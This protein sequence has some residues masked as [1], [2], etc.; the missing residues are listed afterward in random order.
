[1]I[2]SPRPLL[3][4]ARQRVNFPYFTAI[5]ICPSWAACLIT[6]VALSGRRQGQEAIRGCSA[7]DFRAATGYDNSKVPIEWCDCANDESF[8]WKNV[9][10]NEYF[11]LWRSQIDLSSRSEL[12]LFKCGQFRPKPRPTSPLAAISL[13]LLPPVPSMLGL[14]KSV[15]P[16]GKNSLSL[17]TKCKWATHFGSAWRSS[18]N[19]S[20]FN[21]EKKKEK[22]G[23]ERERER[24]GH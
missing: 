22:N 21:G 8:S 10:E 9:C 16:S 18:R 12:I 6:L 3:H 14:V 13:C 2:S 20:A 5:S 15:H 23:R 17:C 19:S 7:E 4:T 1:M 11:L 24:D